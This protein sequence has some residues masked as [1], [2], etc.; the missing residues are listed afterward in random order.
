MCEGKRI[1]IVARLP[2]GGILTFF[3]YIYGQ[4]CFDKYDFTVIVPVK[5]LQVTLGKY[6]RMVVLS[7][8][9]VMMVW[10]WLKRHGF[11]SRETA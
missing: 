2:V 3:K 5:E 1:L 8:L 4:D 9:Y 7:L 6:F 10:T 11:I